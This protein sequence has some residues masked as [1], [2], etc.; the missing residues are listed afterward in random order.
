MIVVTSQELPG[1]ETM[2][3]ERMQHISQ[4]IQTPAL[5]PN[6]RGSGSA[7]RSMYGG[8]VKWERGQRDDGQDSIAV[9]VSGMYGESI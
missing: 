7:C 4:L 5:N 8:F 6:R 1:D 9:Q 3:R 2:P